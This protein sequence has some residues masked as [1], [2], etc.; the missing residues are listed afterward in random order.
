[1]PYVTICDKMRKGGFCTPQNTTANGQITWTVHVIPSVIF[2]ILSEAT[3]VLVLFGWVTT[4]TL[5]I[6][7]PASDVAVS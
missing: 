1:M 4:V 6:P 7:E 2:V 3:V 5:T